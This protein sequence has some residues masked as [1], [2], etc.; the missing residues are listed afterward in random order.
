LLTA[1]NAAG[2]ANGQ[3]HLTVVQD[4]FAN[5]AAS[6]GLTGTNATPAA[7]PDHDGLI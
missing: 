3:F 1:T 5:W 4:A 6:Y 2:S 7:D